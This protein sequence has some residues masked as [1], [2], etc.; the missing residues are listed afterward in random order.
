MNRCVLSVAAVVLSLAFCG[1]A[2]AGGLGRIGGGHMGGLS[3]TGGLGH[4]GGGQG[5]LGGM[6]NHGGRPGLLGHNNLVGRKDAFRKAN[7][8]AGK[9]AGKAP[10]GKFKPKRKG[11]GGGP[12]IGDIIDAAESLLPNRN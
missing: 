2:T 7:A 11:S 9:I 6:L 4:L 8:G 10:Q 3:H 12:D 1:A 5:H